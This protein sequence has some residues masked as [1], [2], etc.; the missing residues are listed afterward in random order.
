MTLLEPTTDELARV[1]AYLARVAS[2]V[3]WQAGVGGM[4]TAGSFVSF[5]ATNPERAGD[6]M[7]GSLV[8]LPFPLHTEGC[9]SWHGSAGKIHNP[10]DIRADRGRLEQ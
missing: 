10:R 6:F 2:D 1:C 7:Q 9:L 4:E 3:A 8:D 5:I